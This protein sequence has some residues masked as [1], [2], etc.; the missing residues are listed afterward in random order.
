[1]KFDITKL[2]KYLTNFEI[3]LFYFFSSKNQNEVTTVINLKK[4]K[5]KI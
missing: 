2:K 4:F 5:L 1:M 3:Y